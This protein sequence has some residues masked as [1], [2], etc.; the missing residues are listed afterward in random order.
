MNRKHVDWLRQELRAWQAEG[1]LSA[2]QAQK[3]LARPG[4]AALVAGVPSNKLVR[5]FAALGA[6]LVGTGLI[7]FFSSNWRAIP[8]GG[9]LTLILG[10]ILGAH[11]LAFRLKFK[12]PGSPGLAAG[13][14]LLGSIAYGSGIFL[15]AQIYNF[16]AEWRAGILLWFLGTLPLAYAVDSR[17]VLWLSLGALVFWISSEFALL[18]VTVLQQA[19]GGILILVAFRHWH[20]F[21][22]PRF[23]KIYFTL[24]SGL[25]LYTTLVLSFESV[26]AAFTRL[27][28]A[29]RFPTYHITLLALYLAILAGVILRYREISHPAQR[30]L[31]LFLSAALAPGI[32]LVIISPAGPRFLLF[33][34]LLLFGESIGLILFGIASRTKAYLN[35]GLA[36]F[37]ILVLCRYFDSYWE[38]LPRSLFF[39][40]GGLL[41]LVLGYVLEKKRRQWTARMETEPAR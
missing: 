26:V 2:E 7:L 20:P 32:F 6:L 27:E 17:P 36:F 12:S 14:F 41:L 33:V 10:S 13:L 40:L 22:L 15:V 18:R 28:P 4:Y 25:I 35:L 34:N 5:L 38:Y 31:V 37:L 29:A 30:R 1:L 3:I 16:H 39:V 21:R 19:L 9:K 23:A 24:G 11:L 8:D